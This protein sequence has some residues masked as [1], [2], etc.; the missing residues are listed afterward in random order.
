MAWEQQ[1]ISLGKPVEGCHSS[2]RQC[3][4][5]LAP[6]DDRKHKTRCRNEEP[7]IDG[8]E[9]AWGVSILY[10]T[11]KRALVHVIQLTLST[12][13]GRIKLRQTLLDSAAETPRTC[14]IVLKVVC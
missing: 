13:C 10:S 3:Q 2:C 4:P 14:F 7:A 5:F 1:P 11:V 6:L 12:W 8:G 9:V